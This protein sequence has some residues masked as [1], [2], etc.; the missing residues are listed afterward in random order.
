MPPPLLKMRKKKKEYVREVQSN[1]ESWLL[2][3]EEG[4]ILF[5]QGKEK[6]KKFVFLPERN[7]A[8]NSSPWI[9]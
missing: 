3:L 7:N 9:G 1:E 8:G 5:P 4:M 6:E 2:S